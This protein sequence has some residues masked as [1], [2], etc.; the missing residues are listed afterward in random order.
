MATAIEEAER[1]LFLHPWSTSD[2]DNPVDLLRDVVKDFRDDLA[3][4]VRDAQGETSTDEDDEIESPRVSKL[5]AFIKGLRDD[6][7]ISEAEY[8]TALHCMDEPAII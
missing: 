3:E 7:K 4:A 2:V 1:F 8:Q 5:L 6:L